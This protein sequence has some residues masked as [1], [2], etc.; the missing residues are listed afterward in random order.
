VA[1]D[2]SSPAPDSGRRSVLLR[3]VIAGLVVVALGVCAIVAR[4]SGVDGPMLQ[5]EL[6]ALGCFAPP[7]F[8]VLFAAGELLHLPGILFVLVARVVFGPSLG[9]VLGYGGALLALTL[10]F[11]VARQVV[12]AARATKEPWR[13]KWRLLR[14]AFDRVESHPIQTIALLRLVLWLSPPL[15][16]ALASTGVRARDHVIGTAIGIVLPVLGVAVLGGYL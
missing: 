11:A 7:L 3:R 6:L 16:Y 8:L 10:A 9:F 12:S 4:R 15:S 5:R 14:R 1:L 2:T 13:P